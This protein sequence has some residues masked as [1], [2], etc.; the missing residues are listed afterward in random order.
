MT[1][2]TKTEIKYMLKAIGVLIVT[3]IVLSYIMGIG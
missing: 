1:E 3:G 2:E